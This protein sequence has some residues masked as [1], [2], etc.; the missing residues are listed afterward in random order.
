M[1]LASST[2]LTPATAASRSLTHRATSS[3]T[4]A[5]QRP[6][7][8]QQTAH[9]L[10]PLALPLMALATSTLQTPP[11]TA[12][13]SLTHRATSSHTLAPQRPAPA[14]QTAH[15]I[16][17]MALPLMALAT[18]TSLTRTTTGLW[19]SPS[20]AP[21]RQA[22]FCQALLR[23]ALLRPA[24]LRLHPA[25]PRPALTRNPLCRPQPRPPRLRPPGVQLLMWWDECGDSHN[26][27]P[28]SQFP[29]SLLHSPPPATKTFVVQNK[30]NT[31]GQK[32]SCSA[33]TTEAQSATNSATIM[34]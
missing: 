1:A 5:P 9:S 8:A 27:M 16:P 11:T 34:L 31:V 30:F 21:L 22:L 2:S 24:P 29:P 32:A 23:Q 12:S 7:S 10:T 4:L 19:S 6:A 18:S 3:H 26:L 14:Q 28:P 25:L 15:S 13:K 17:P 33:W 20:Q